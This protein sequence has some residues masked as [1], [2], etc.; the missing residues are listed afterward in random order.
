MNGTE[1]SIF[2]IFTMLGGL[3]FFLYGMNVMSTGLEKLTGGKLEVALKKMTSNRF[4]AIILGMVVTIAIQSSSAMTVMLVGFVNSGLM[5]LEQTVGV[6]FGSD[7][8]TT[9]TAWI[10]SLAGVDGTNPFIKMLKPTSFAP[11]VAIIGVMLIMGAKKNKHKDVGRIL[12]GFAIIMTGMSLMSDSVSPLANSPKFQQILTAFHNPILGVLVGAGFTGVIQ[13]SAASVGILQAFSQTGA[14]TYGMALP[15]IMGLNIGTCVTALISSIGVN[16]NAKRVACIHILIKVLG[17][18]ILLPVALI[19]QHVVQL[20]IFDEP[21]GYVGIAVMHSIFNIATTI[22]LLPFTPMLVKLSRIIVRDKEGGESETEDNRLRGLDERFLKTPAVAVETCRSTTI[23]MA[24]ITSEAIND[25]LELL[26][27]PYNAE[28]VRSVIDAEDLIDH[29]ED[30]INSYLVRLSKSSITGKDSRRV[31]KMMHCVGNFERI[32]DHA[33]NLIE[34]VQECKEKGIKFSD[35]CINELKVITEAISENISTAFSSYI[36]NDLGAAHKVEPL[37]EV[38]D[39]LST[40]LKNR[41][42]RR[43]QNDECTVELG[44]IFQDIL[45]NLERISD[46]CSNIAGCLIET[47]EKTNLHAYLHDVKEND[48]TFRNEFRTYSE[49]YFAKL[50]EVEANES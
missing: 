50:E 36:T 29:Y 44:Y 21:V 22:I 10:L 49:R 30:K 37:E 11:I 7:I 6:C 27:S 2:N 35:E 34:S 13:S 28:K 39:N 19:L 20:G 31:A 32:S 43:L 12:V 25:A 9:L 48:E 40:E 41:H 18:L 38:V 46:H 3:A 16:K 14:L 8:G 15:I 23:E 45:T 33:V 17:T 4:M 42:I 5:S 26:V 24:N 1:F 47:D